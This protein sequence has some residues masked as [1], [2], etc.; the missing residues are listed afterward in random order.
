MTAYP[1][2][3][4]RHPFQPG[5]GVT[6]GHQPNQPQQPVAISPIA[7]EANTLVVGYT[8]SGADRI[9]AQTLACRAEQGLAT[10][11]MDP[12][13]NLYRELTEHTAVTSVLIS[14]MPYVTAHNPLAADAPESVSQ[15]VSIL[16]YTAPVWGNRIAR[17]VTAAITDFRHHNSLNRNGALSLRDL[18]EITLQPPTEDNAGLLCHGQPIASANPDYWRPFAEWPADTLNDT[19]SAV[20]AIGLRASSSRHAG[21]TAEQ[22]AEHI[23]SGQSVLFTIADQVPPYGPPL[24]IS[25]LLLS[26]LYHNV[27]QQA[28]AELRRNPVDLMLIADHYQL[29]SGVDWDGLTSRDNNAT[30]RVMLS[31]LEPEVVAGA[32]LPRPVTAVANC[33]TLVV[34]PTGDR[35][36]TA[37]SGIYPIGDHAADAL[38]RMQH[39]DGFLFT[40]AYG[41]P[42]G[43]FFQEADTGGLR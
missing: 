1:V 8:G 36:I 4:K 30:L 37:L 29:A 14:D 6:V 39:R 41:E 7:L 38:S 10:I 28:Q 15:I 11:G 19:F 21:F 25:D 42:A 35:Q 20:R 26:C 34:R 12:V 24:N 33:G 17:V 9:L 18:A 40:T 5:D 13:G 32:W 43:V 2:P 3:N 27:I 22:L 31:C 16:G 23:R